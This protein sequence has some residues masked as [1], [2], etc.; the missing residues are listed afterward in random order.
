MLGSYSIA[1]VVDD[2]NKRPTKT[3]F[4]IL[5]ICD[6]KEYHD[7][8]LKSLRMVEKMV[9]SNGARVCH[10]LDDVADTLN[11]LSS[12]TY[13]TAVPSS[14]SIGEVRVPNGYYYN[15]ITNSMNYDTALDGSILQSI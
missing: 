11:G 2:S 13:I 5:P 1:E 6:G 3:I 10:S 7:R 12:N 4:C 8:E 14:S 9:A 15:T